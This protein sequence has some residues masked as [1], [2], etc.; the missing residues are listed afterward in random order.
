LSY[1]EF[2]V[3]NIFSQCPQQICFVVND[4]P[5]SNLGVTAF[6]NAENSFISLNLTWDKTSS[7]KSVDIQLEEAVNNK[8]FELTELTH[9]L[10]VSVQ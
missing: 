8:G 9:N 1:A 6:Y 2:D 4:C 7:N 5:V 3:K 10:N